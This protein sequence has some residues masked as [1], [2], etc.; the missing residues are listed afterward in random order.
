LFILNDYVNK[1][2][3]RTIDGLIGLHQSLGC[4]QI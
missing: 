2:N 4:S 3:G 1:K